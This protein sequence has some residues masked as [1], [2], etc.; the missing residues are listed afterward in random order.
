MLE[1]KTYYGGSCLMAEEKELC[2]FILPVAKTNIQRIITIKF[3][4]SA[5]N[6]IFIF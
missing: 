6:S 5:Y 2:A 4:L 1:A 3:I